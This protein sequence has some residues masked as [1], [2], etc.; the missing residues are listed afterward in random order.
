MFAIQ[1]YNFPVVGRITL[2]WISAKYGGL[3]WAGFMLLRVET[4]DRLL[5]TQ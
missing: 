4:N 2:K 1:N 5:L 3:V